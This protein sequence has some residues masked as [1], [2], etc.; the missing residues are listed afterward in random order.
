MKYYYN[1]NIGNNGNNGGPTTAD[2]GPVDNCAGVSCSIPNEEC[3][4][5]DGICKCGI[6]DTCEGKTNA[7][8]CSGLTDPRSCQCGSEPACG[9]GQTCDPASGQ[10]S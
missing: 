3:D 4:P 1:T 10:C 5:A 8:T 7:P 2:P 6:E 9:L